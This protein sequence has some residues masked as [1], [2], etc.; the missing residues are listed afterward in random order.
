MNDKNDQGV[1]IY[2]KSEQDREKV[3]DTATTYE[4]YIIHVNETLQLENRK[5]HHTVE[6]LETQ[7]EELTDECSRHERGVIHTKGFLHNLVLM[8]RLT[9]EKSEKL[10]HIEKKTSK[11]VKDHQVKAMKHFRYLQIGLAVI[12]SLLWEYQVFSTNQSVILCTLLAVYTAFHHATLQDLVLPNVNE[13][14]TRMKKIKEELK[15]LHEGNDFLN[16]YIDLL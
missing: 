12:M 16:E 14:L 3:L 15:E 4:K 6:S 2:L 13:E 5:L 8:Q 9:D 1:H 11:V 7:V 10:E